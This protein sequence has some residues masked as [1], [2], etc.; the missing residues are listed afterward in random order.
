[1]FFLCILEIEEQV[2]NIQAKKAQLQAGPKE[3]NPEDDRVGL[4]AEGHYDVD[5]YGG[6]DSRFDGY[7]TSI[8]ATDEIDV[9]YLCSFKSLF[10]LTDY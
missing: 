8:A 4:G 9:M 5:I 3:N 7:V 2:R 10:C 1:M 6:S